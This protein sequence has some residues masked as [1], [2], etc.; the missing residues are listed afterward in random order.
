MGSERASPIASYRGT[1]PD[2]ESVRP[3]G[4]RRATLPLPRLEDDDRSARRAANGIAIDVVA[5][6]LPAF[7]QPGSLVANRLAA[8]DGTDAVDE[9]DRRLGVRLEVEPPGRFGLGP[10][11]HRHRDEVRSVLVV[12]EDRTP[13]LARSAAERRE[14]HRPP[15]V[16]LRP[17]ETLPAARQP[18]ESPMEQPRADHDEARRQPRGPFRSVDQ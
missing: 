10:A 13:L 4:A 11:V 14:T 3:V 6:V 8:A 17:P 15:A 7:P 5:H 1:E 18:M 9:L 12:A 16:R 2:I